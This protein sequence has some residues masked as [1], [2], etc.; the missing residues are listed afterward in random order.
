MWNIIGRWSESKISETMTSVTLIFWWTTM[1]STSP[2]PAWKQCVGHCCAVISSWLASNKHKSSLPEG[3]ET[4]LFQN[5]CLAF[6]SPASIDLRLSLIALWCQ[7]H[8]R[9]NFCFLWHSTIELCHDLLY[10]SYDSLHI[11][12]RVTV[13]ISSLIWLTCFMFLCRSRYNH[14]V[15]L[16]RVDLPLGLVVPE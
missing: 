7:R 10:Y 6:R 15:V 1:C 11:V 9:H 5:G 3:L 16:W 12:Q 8:S 4:A 2:L 13:Y 14:P